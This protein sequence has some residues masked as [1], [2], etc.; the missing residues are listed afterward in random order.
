MTKTQR[1]AISYKQY[2]LKPTTTIKNLLGHDIKILNVK[3]NDVILYDDSV[4]VDVEYTD[5][6]IN[7]SIIHYIPLKNFKSVIPNG[8]TLV[9]IIDNCAVSVKLRDKPF[10][11]I[12][13]LRINKMQTNNTVDGEQVEQ[14]FSYFGTP[15]RNPLSSY[16]SILK[17]PN[18]YAMYI[19][20]PE[21]EKIYP[22]GFK[23]EN[24]IS[25]EKMLRSYQSAIK[26]IRS[27]NI[28]TNLLRVKSLE[29]CVEYTKGYLIDWNV[30]KQSTSLKGIILIQP[31]RHVFTVLFIPSQMY[32]IDE[33]EL[34]SI[35]RLL[36]M[37]YINYMNYH[38]IVN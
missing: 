38:Y 33:E 11:N 18:T 5:I 1:L 24:V 12:I 25:E 21:I 26:K 8:T 2:N 35:D 37:D 27:L 23:F 14:V 34:Q 17:I 20:P 10:K 29:E 6:H 28:I 9:T 3:K 36:Q 31:E 19:D 32:K 22:S 4:V 13:P 16:C 30:L 15:V 7:N